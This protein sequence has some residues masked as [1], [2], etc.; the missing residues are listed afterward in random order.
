MLFSNKEED[1]KTEKAF[2]N[3]QVGDRFTE[4]YSFWLYVVG[5][6][7]DKV[8]T[9]EASPPC[10][11]P[12]DGKLKVQTVEDFRNRFAYG[13]ISGYSLHFVDGDNNVEGWFEE[14]IWKEK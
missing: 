4:M 2:S 9:I 5:K 8:A 12:E 1:A 11:F 13:S 14:G 3:P 7:G 10:S 6:N